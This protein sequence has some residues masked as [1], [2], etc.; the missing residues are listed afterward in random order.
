MLTRVQVQLEELAAELYLWR[1]HIFPVPI[2]QTRDMYS[3]ALDLAWGGVLQGETQEA[4]GLFLNR[5]EHINVKEFRGAL[6][7]VDVY[8]LPHTTIRFLTDSLVLYWYLCKRG[9]RKPQ[10]KAPI[11]Q[12]C[13]FTQ[14]NHITIQLFYVHLSFNPADVWSRL[15][16][17]PS[18]ASF[19]NDL[20]HFILEDFGRWI[21]PVID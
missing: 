19:Q 11:R 12:L 1:G 16:L 13:K 2:T 7:T 20:K 6:M 18:E 10:F 14:E 21:M 5:E 3:D 15:R 9:G 8:A 17:T 4:F